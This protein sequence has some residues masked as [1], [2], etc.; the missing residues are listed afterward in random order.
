[1]TV[2]IHRYQISWGTKQENEVEIDLGAVI[3]NS[4]SQVDVEVLAD[5]ADVN[6]IY[7]ESLLNL[8]NRKITPKPTK[9]KQTDAEKEMA[10]KNYYASVRTNVSIGSICNVLVT[11]ADMATGSSCLGPIKCELF[12]HAHSTHA[13]IYIQGVLLAGILGGGDSSVTFTNDTFSRTKAYMTFILSFVAITSIIVSATNYYQNG[14]FLTTVPNSVSLV[15]PCISQHVYLQ[16][17]DA[18]LSIQGLFTD[19]YQM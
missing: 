9:T 4:E 14:A 2:L 18:L 11:N 1:M 8:K 12:Y 16:D 13:N 17:R 19:I 15:L 10:A 3:Q 6:G 5:I 7:E